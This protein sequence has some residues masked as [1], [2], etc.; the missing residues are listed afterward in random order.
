MEGAM[1]VAIIRGAGVVAPQFF[2]RIG[3]G[4]RGRLCH[5]AHRGRRA[6][7]PSANRLRDS[8]A[9]RFSRNAA[10][11]EMVKPGFGSLSL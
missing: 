2:V 6:S 7:A 3:Q 5:S 11:N 9:A 4:G 1:N 10:S 8:D